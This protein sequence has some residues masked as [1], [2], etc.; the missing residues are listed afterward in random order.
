MVLGCVCALCA[1]PAACRKGATG[2]AG[3]ARTAATPAAGTV[4]IPGALEAA[5]AVWVSR[6]VRTDNYQRPDV[7]EKIVPEGTRVKKGDFL[8]QLD[9]APIERELEKEQASAKTL[10][11]KVVSAE[12]R[13]AELNKKLEAA[14]E[15]RLDELVAKRPELAELIRKLEGD[16][17]SEI[18]DTQMGE[19]KVWLQRQGIRLD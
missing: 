16:Y 13:L 19:L 11:L 6:L 14:E 10:E 18:F 12:S 7:L 4:S 1:L 3:P 15:K 2:T 17:D 8:F 5:D 9:L